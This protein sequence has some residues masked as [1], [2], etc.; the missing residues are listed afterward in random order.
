MR[1]GV[2]SEGLIG[3]QEKHGVG[4]HGESRGVLHGCLGTNLCLANSHEL[5]FITEIDLD[6]PSPDI[7]LDDLLERESRVGAQQI[8]GFSVQ[9]SAFFS[10]AIAKRSDDNEP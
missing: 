6:V 10:K 2:I 3:C 8:G 5:F 9:E 7:C 4:G 1:D